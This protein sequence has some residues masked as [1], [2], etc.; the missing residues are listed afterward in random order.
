MEWVVSSDIKEG[1]ESSLYYDKS[2]GH[3]IAF[4][5]LPQESPVL[6]GSGSKNKSNTFKVKFL[7]VG[8]FPYNCQI[9]T[10]MKGLI[11]VFD[12]QCYSKMPTVKQIKNVHAMFKAAPTTLE[13]DSCLFKKGKNREELGQKLIEVLG[14]EKNLSE[15]DSEAIKKEYFVEVFDKY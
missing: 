6:S 11:K 3:V 2:R 12:K 5:D 10:R 7:E 8:S 9:Y 14:E 4:K 13:S 15:G 1:N